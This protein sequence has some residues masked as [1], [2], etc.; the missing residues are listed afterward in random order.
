[1]N[2]NERRQ[3]P[4][5]KVR[6]FATIYLG[7]EKIYASVINITKAG[8]GITSIKKLPI[9]EVIS[10]KIGC[11]IGEKEKDNVHMKAKVLWIKGLAGDRVF[12]AGL[13]I[14]EVAKEDVEKFRRCI[15]NLMEHSEENR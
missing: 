6:Y 2:F 11:K 4:R 7:N 10:L 12:I 1:M 5:F 14:I 3:Y 9:D 13:K 8:L 15:Q